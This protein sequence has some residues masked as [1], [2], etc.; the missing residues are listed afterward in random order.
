MIH[1]VQKW[2]DKD[3]LN[4]ILAALGPVE[5]DGELYRAGEHLGSWNTDIYKLAYTEKVFTKHDRK[6]Y[7]FSRLTDGSLHVE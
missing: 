4:I 1:S 7:Q 3:S 5:V 2:K 6:L